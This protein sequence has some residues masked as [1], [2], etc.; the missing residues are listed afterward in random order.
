MID[1]FEKALLGDGKSVLTIQ[2]YINDIRQFAKWLKDSLGFESDSI[3]ETDVR[4]YRQYLN[5][6]RKLKPTSI[7]RKLKS[8]VAYQKFLVREGICKEAIQLKKVLSKH[9]FD[10]NQEIKIVDKQN[11]Y[12][13]KRT[14]ESESNRR[15]ICIYYLLFGTGIRVSELVNCEIDD[16]VLTERNGKNNYSY[17][18]IRNGKGNKARKVNLNAAAVNAL[19][20]YLEVRPKGTN[21]LLIGQRGPLTRMAINKILD[22]YS[23]K[24]QLEQKVS[25]HLCRHTFCTDLI[26]NGSDPKTVALLSGHS[27]V[28]TIYQYYVSSSAEDKQRAVDSLQI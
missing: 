6:Q 20:D 19:R 5:L 17:I 18:L 2:A 14:I 7:N 11:M 15:D 27:S 28:N 13:L 8:V 25:P 21:K 3:T 16:L 12:R 24:A 10:L 23:R 9:T 26:K 4:E 22:K 1:K